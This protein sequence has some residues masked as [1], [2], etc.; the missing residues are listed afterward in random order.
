MGDG[1]RFMWTLYILI[2]VGKVVEVAIMTIRTV[3]VAKGE[4]K[5]GTVLAFFEIILWIMLVSKVIGNLSNDPY[6]GL[7]YALGFTAGTY[8]GSTLENLFGI[9]TSQLQ[10]IVSVDKAEEMCEKIYNKGF[11]YTKVDAM[12]R[13]QDRTIIYTLLP[14][15]SVRKVLKDLRTVSEDALMSVH[16]IKP[17]RGGYGIKRK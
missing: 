8:V 14:R 12:G 17:I 6:S 16:E 4:K 15:S 5:L 3:L 10:I 11:A 13:V 2:F 1:E 7:A 9:G